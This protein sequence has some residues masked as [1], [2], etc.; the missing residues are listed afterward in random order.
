M[1][2][3]LLLGV[4]VTAALAACDGPNSDQTGTPILPT[5]A[6]DVALS[7]TENDSTRIESWKRELIEADQAFS[8]AIAGEG[9]G[10]WSS[11]F[12][13]DGAVIREGVGEIRGADAVQAS[14]DAGAEAVMD[15]RWVPERAEVSASGDLGYTVGRARILLMG[16]DNVEMVTTSMYVSIWRRQETGEWKV[17]M[18][19]GNTMTNPTPVPDAETQEGYE[20]S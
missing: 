7:T 6:K 20:S 11:F 16:P 14:M 18:D 10:R 3:R 2:T 5:D 13:E 1:K 4:A 9:L 12:T 8:A 19:L 15:F 17:E